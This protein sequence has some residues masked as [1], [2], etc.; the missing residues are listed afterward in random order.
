[1][2]MAPCALKGDVKEIGFLANKIVKHIT[3]LTLL[4]RDHKMKS[5]GWNVISF[6][7]IERSQMNNI[8]GKRVGG[9]T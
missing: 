8:N 4:G 7:Q 6:S 1:M 5:Q 9:I 2:N 3:L